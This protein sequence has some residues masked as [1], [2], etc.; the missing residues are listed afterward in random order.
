MA[1]PV[2]FTVTDGNAAALLDFLRKV[3][4]DG[5]TNSFE[6]FLN[7]KTQAGLRFVVTDGIVNLMSNA[8]AT[9]TP[10]SPVPTYAL[11]AKSEA[12]TN[13]LRRLK[14]QVLNLSSVTPGQTLDSMK[15]PILEAMVLVDGQACKEAAFNKQ[16]FGYGDS[17]V[18]TAVLPE[19]V[20][21]V[22]LEI[23]TPDGHVITTGSATF[24][25]AKAVPGTMLRS[26]HGQNMLSRLMLEPSTPATKESLSQLGQD[27]GIVTPGT[28]LLVLES[29][30]QYLRYKVRPP[31]SALKERQLYDEAIA[32]THTQKELEADKIRL[33]N[34]KA[35]LD[36]WKNLTEWY[37]KDFPKEATKSVPA[38]ISSFQGRGSG[39]L[40]NGIASGS[41]RAGNAAI[42]NEDI[43]RVLDEQRQR[44]ESPGT[45][46]PQDALAAPFENRDMG[47]S[48][49]LEDSGPFGSPG[50]SFAEEA[51]A[52]PAPLAKAKTA[53]SSSSV[54]APAINVKAWNP[55]SPYLAALNTSDSPFQ[56]Y[57]K[58]KET[59][60]TSPGFYLDCADWFAKK[61]DRETAVQ[62]LSNL[63]EME[64]E[65]RSLMR[66]LGYKLRY[67][68]DLAAA[69]A[70]FSQV[71]DLFPEEPQS[72][73][74]LALVLDEMG[75]SQ[76][77][78]DTLKLVLEKPMHP[79]FRGIEQIVLVEM[80][81]I[82][83]RAKDAGKPVDTKGLD[84]TFI[85]PITTDIRVV[86]NWDTDNSDMDLW[87]T[88]RFSEK[89]FYS[90]NRTSTGG[91]LSRDVT[92]GY[93]PEEFMI[94]KAV[95]GHYKIEAN[96]YGS[97]SQ[98]MLAPVTLYAEVYSDYARPTEKRQTLVFRLSG[99]N[100]VVHIGDIAYTP[101]AGATVASTRDYQVRKGDTMET[102]AE[103]ELGDKARADEIQKING[104]EQQSLPVT[105]SIIKLPIR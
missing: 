87:A 41:V 62:I 43:D 59:Q 2:T 93:G 27:Y 85:K 96:Y 53:T 97:R 69:H 7:A 68:G 20:H 13:A 35:A 15:H 56:T 58:L 79:R 94:R 5:G 55:D 92:D 17:L 78:F 61:G 49:E 12:D 45:P 105:G 89:C 30:D 54:P 39:D 25:T 38:K 95:P 36:G 8:D 48:I 72:Y 51:A 104:W 101:E 77:A 67:L 100:D 3:R 60:G 52:A 57:L 81:R 31:A 32:K 50:D 1:E 42:S 66:V 28:S 46:R 84:T 22:K 83:T 88:D 24:D 16:G 73:R 82:I 103:R 64:L 99:R 19:G 91:H 18:W 33:D 4:Y 34:L 70:I 47:Q 23:K 71:L 11:V 98:K 90:H 102:I 9:A 37:A 40:G 75:D 63:A 26:F 86:I 14:M 44:R 76:A 74:D 65:N 10:S 6:A 80:N 21:N 29:L